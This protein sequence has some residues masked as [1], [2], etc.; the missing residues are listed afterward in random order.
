VYGPHGR[1]CSLTAT[2]KHFMAGL[3]ACAVCSSLSPPSPHTPLPPHS[4]IHNYQP[5]LLG[6]NG[7][8]AAARGVAKKPSKPAK[9]RPRKR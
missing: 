1:S 2:A 4:A 7:A 6:A 8:A 5:P 9:K 3:P